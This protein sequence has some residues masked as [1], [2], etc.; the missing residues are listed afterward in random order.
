MGDLTFSSDGERG[1]VAGI[2]TAGATG[3]ASGRATSSSSAYIAIELSTRSRSRLSFDSRLLPAFVSS[4]ADAQNP[5]MT[6]KGSSSID[7][8]R[9]R[10]GLLSTPELGE[11]GAVDFGGVSG[12]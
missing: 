9:A 8:V 11:R 5:E 6:R 3:L 12:I 2:C 4:F 1:L 7:I 10:G